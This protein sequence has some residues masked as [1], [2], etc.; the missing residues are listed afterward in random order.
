MIYGALAD[1]VV[2]LHLAFIVFVLFGGFLSLRW[3]WLPWLHLPAAA[4]GAGIELFGWVCPLTPLENQ[5]RHV[6]DVEGYSGG[7]I[8]EYLLPLVYPPGLTHSIQLLLG[9][10]VIA[11]NLVAYGIFWRHRRRY[12]Q[13]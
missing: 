1:L 8:E 9:L 7:F 10:F 13:S 2:F 6:A 3:R 4:W 5:L 12:H 11:V